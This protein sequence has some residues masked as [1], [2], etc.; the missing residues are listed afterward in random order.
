VRDLQCSL[1]ESARGGTRNHHHP[2]TS[3]CSGI[4]V[5]TRTPRLRPCA[6]YNHDGRIC[7]GAPGEPPRCQ[8]RGCHTPASPGSARSVHHWQPPHW[9]PERPVCEAGAVRSRWS[10]RDGPLGTIAATSES[11]AVG[12][13]PRVTVPPVAESAACQPEYPGA[14]TRSLS[15]SQRGPPHIEQ[16]AS[17][18]PRRRGAQAS[19]AFSVS[20]SEAPGPQ[21]SNLKMPPRRSTDVRHGQRPHHGTA[22]VPPP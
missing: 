16:R 6:P 10:G 9:Q 17:V 21:A 15:P 22:P 5:P 14:P 20:P 3:Q 13:L 11:R 19:G 18:P 2:W 4:D 8:W 12:D 7:G 1:S